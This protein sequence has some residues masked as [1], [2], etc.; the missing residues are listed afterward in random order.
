MMR[1]PNTAPQLSKLWRHSSFKTEISATG[2][3]QR[4]R[5]SRHANLW[6]E[7]PLILIKVLLAWLL[8]CKQC[9]PCSADPAM[10]R[11]P[12]EEFPPYMV[13]IVKTLRVRTQNKLFTG[14]SVYGSVT[15]LKFHIFVKV[16][17]LCRSPAVQN[18]TLKTSESE[19]LSPVVSVYLCIQIQQH[20]SMP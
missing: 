3:C 1:I 10:L 18:F 5:G 12:A 6:K 7:A 19:T 9:C 4:W 2:S 13:S 8:W 20:I 16:L 14:T 17:V 11:C 15:V